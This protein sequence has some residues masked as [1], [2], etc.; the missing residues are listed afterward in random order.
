MIAAL[1]DRLK[2]MHDDL[3]ATVID[4]KSI[5]VTA[6]RE[7]PPRI[8]KAKLPLCYAEFLGFTEESASEQFV[9][10]TYRFQVELLVQHV[11]ATERDASGVVRA[12]HEANALVGS[13][14]AYY[15]AHRQGS[16]SALPDLDAVIAP[17]AVSCDS[18]ELI[19]SYDGNPYV[20]AVFT[21]EIQAILEE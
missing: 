6:Y 5:T 13:L 1:L 2:L 9:Q 19:I 8:E 10:R 7:A 16:T 11:G 3:P 21:L 18:G 14:D 15:R 12:V 17:M 20:G 4:G